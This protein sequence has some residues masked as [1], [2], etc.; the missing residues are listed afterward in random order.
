MKIRGSTFEAMSA[1]T[2]GQSIADKLWPKLLHDHDF[3]LSRYEAFYKD[4]HRYPELS[5][6]EHR[7]ASKIVA[8]L[9]ELEPSLEIRTGIGGT[10]LIAILRN[11]EGKTLLLRADMDALPLLEKTG[12]DYASD[13]K[14]V[15]C[16]GK[17]VS[18]MH[19]RLIRVFFC[20][21]RLTS[22]HSVRP[23]L[24]YNVSPRRCRPSHILPQSLV[25]NADISLST[26]RR[27]SRWCKSNGGR[28][29]IHAARVSH[30]RFGLGSTRWAFKSRN[31]F[32]QGRASPGGL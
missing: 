14:A 2:K 26:G 17:V 21:Q 18:V 22:C 6:Q 4:V 16:D 30:P 29:T 13:E 32:P 20:Y 9:R 8:L 3:D 12:L 5:R 28:W 24:P 7:T 19:G 11:G 1:K 15:D 27:G 31:G 10:G 25:R 23:Q